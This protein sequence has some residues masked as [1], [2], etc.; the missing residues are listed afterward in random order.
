MVILCVK[1][2]FHIVE[3]PHPPGMTGPTGIKSKQTK[4]GRGRQLISMQ[5]FHYRE[6]HVLV[7]MMIV[8]AGQIAGRADW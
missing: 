5:Q 6:F 7:Q 2:E 8:P 3:Y 4:T 1:I